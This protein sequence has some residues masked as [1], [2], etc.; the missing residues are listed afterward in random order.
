MILISHRGLMD[1]PNKEL[2]NRPDII[3]EISN[4]GI[5]V[6]VDLWVH[7]SRLIL[8]HDEPQ[9]E[10]DIDFFDN[11][12]LVTHA[13]NLEALTFLTKELRNHN[14]F[15]HTDDDYVLTSRKWIWAYPGSPLNSS[16]IAVIPETIMPISE[17][18][19]LDVY[20]V[21]SDYINQIR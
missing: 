18:K 11:H 21:C 7:G 12:M 16:C 20:G 2:E 5:Y 3:K 15:W 17:I 8:G 13:K 9:Y 6:E 1:G 19:N 14:F 4:S 10:V